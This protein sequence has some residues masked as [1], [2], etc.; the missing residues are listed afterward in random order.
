MTDPVSQPATNAPQISSDPAA[1]AADQ[2]SP[3]DILEQLL[4]DSKKDDATAPAAS[5]P[6][7]SDPGG[8][9]GSGASEAAPGGDAAAQPAVLTPEQ[10]AELDAKLAAQ[11]ELD[12]QKV[13]QT[14]HELDSVKVSPQY[15]ARVQQQEEEA[16]QKQEEAIEHDGHQIH[17]IGH[18]KI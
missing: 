1:S 12:Q 14:L 5:N 18:T 8:I 6:G 2:K 13:E 9:V 15:Q 10:I 4:K 11:R 16:H 17:Q 3:L 7:A